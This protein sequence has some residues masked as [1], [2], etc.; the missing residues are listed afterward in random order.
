MYTRR[1]PCKDE[2]WDAVTLYNSRTTKSAS[3]QPA[4]RGEA[5]N[6]LFLTAQKEPA[7]LTSWPGL[8]NCE[9]VGFC[10]SKLY[11]SYLIVLI[12]L[13]S[14][15]Y[16]FSNFVYIYWPF[17]NPLSWS[18]YRVF[19]PFLNVCPFLIYLSEFYWYSKYNS[20]VRDVLQIAFPILKLPLAFW[21]LSFGD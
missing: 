14:A 16:L 19:S 1:T 5:W 13:I 9:T 10:P 18:S 11:M 8:Q 3:E 12:V 4:G 21:I 7:L 17:G 2:G 6:G 20:F 15:I